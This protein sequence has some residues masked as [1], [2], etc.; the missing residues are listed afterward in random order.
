MI[1]GETTSVPCR[2]KITPEFLIIISDAETLFQ[3][4]ADKSLKFDAN[5]GE[6]LFLS[7]SEHAF[8]R[9]FQETGANFEKF[10]HLAPIAVEKSQKE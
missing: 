3:K 6:E 5:H 7:Y 4:S 2:A 9:R 1:S 10:R 8:W